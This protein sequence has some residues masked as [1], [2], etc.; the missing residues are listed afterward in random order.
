MGCVTT[1]NS[2]LEPRG[3]KIIMIGG[4]ASGKTS[5]LY[6]LSKRMQVPAIPTVGH[7][8]EYVTFNKEKFVLYDIGSRN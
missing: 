6:Y 2:I 7:N 8:A 1:K 4:K 3:K 5:I